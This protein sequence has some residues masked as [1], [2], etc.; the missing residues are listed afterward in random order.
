MKTFTL[1]FCGQKWLG[2]LPQ[3]NFSVLEMQSKYWLIESFQSSHMNHKI[4]SKHYFHYDHCLLIFWLHSYRKCS[5]ANYWYCFVVACCNLNIS[6][7]TKSQKCRNF[8][9]FLV[10]LY[11]SYSFFYIFLKSPSCILRGLKT[12]L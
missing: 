7:P 5:C 1:H 12:S 9:Y 2:I 6:V 4:L 11:N 8:Q 10:I 3:N